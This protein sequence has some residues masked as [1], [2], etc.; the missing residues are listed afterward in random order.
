MSRLCVS[1]E[2]INTMTL[3]TNFQEYHFIY[4]L[5]LIFREITS[6]FPPEIYYDRVSINNERI[7]LKLTVAT[8]STL[9]K[10]YVAAALI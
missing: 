7:S 4:S 8:M 5:Y 1:G 6:T 9:G 10:A 3:F 2:I